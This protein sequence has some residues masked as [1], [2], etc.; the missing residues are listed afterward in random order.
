MQQS[1]AR[2]SD[3]GVGRGWGAGLGAGRT[4]TSGPDS[5]VKEEKNLQ[6]LRHFS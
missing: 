5:C 1:R 4:L 6:P 2:P 3:G